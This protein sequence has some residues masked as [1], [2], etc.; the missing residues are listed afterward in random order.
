MRA[1]GAATANP[2]FCAKVVA[3]WWK[4]DARCATRRQEPDWAGVL[5]VEEIELEARDVSAN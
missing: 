5:S 3:V 2:R 1:V 4:R